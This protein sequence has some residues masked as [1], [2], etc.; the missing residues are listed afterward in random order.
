MRT[1]KDRVQ[2]GGVQESISVGR[3]RV[4]PRDII[5]ADANGVV[6]VRRY[7]AREVAEIAAKIEKSESD[8]RDMIEKGATIGE[9]RGKVGYHTLQRKG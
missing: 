6:V 9:A 4:N 7:R 5:V 1:G 8:I 3:V 2:V